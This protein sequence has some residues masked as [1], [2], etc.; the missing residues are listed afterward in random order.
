MTTLAQPWPRALRTCAPFRTTAQVTGQGRGCI[1]RGPEP[2]R[3]RRWGGQVCGVLTGTRCGRRDREGRRAP[4][5]GG[6]TEHDPALTFSPLLSAPAP[7]PVWEGRGEARPQTAEHRELKRGSFLR[8]ALFLSV[9]G[10]RCH[11]LLIINAQ[12][13]RKAMS[14]AVSYCEHLAL[15]LERTYA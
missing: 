9:A 5:E 7:R 3:P 1:M 2:Q 4:G 13:S 15:C 12:D 14:S 6:G 8:W 10:G 11:C